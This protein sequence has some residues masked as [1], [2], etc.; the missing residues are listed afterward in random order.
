MFEH[1]LPACQIRIPHCEWPFTCTCPP[2]N[3]QEWPEPD[4]RGAIFRREKNNSIRNA[5]L[6]DA[7]PSRRPSMTTTTDLHYL[8]LHELAAQIRTKRV[9]PVDATR[10][11]LERI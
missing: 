2:V 5:I 8:T 11:A 4:S 1:A 3:S 10:S 9:S 7:P 6:P